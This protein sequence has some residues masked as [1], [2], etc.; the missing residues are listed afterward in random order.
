MFVVCCSFWGLDETLIRRCS[1]WECRFSAQVLTVICIYLEQPL[2]RQVKQESTGPDEQVNILTGGSFIRR[3]EHWSF[4][5]LWVFLKSI[6]FKYIF[7]WVNWESKAE[8]ACYWLSNTKQNNWGWCHDLVGKLWNFHQM[9]VKW[10]SQSIFQ[11][12]SSLAVKLLDTVGLG[13]F[14]WALSQGNRAINVL[15]NLIN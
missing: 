2:I 1:L 13:N 9:E 8:A 5:L 4:H 14:H 12:N 3:A 10:S 7:N 15:Q 6:F 11:L